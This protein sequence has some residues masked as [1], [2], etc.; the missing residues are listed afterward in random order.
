MFK[1]L[2]LPWSSPWLDASDIKISL[3][4]LLE[5]ANWYNSKL[6][7]VVKDEHYLEEEYI[8]QILDRYTVITSTRIKLNNIENLFSIQLNDKDN[9][10]I[11]AKGKFSFAPNG[12]AGFFTDFD[13]CYFTLKI[14]C[15]EGHDSSV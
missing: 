12:D 13:D 6:L 1:L 15:K 8:F 14:Y 11:I 7:G 10:I 9:R 3:F 2:Y 4:L 5:L